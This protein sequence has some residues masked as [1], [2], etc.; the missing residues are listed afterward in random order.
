[1]TRIRIGWAAAPLGLVGAVVAAVV[2]ATAGGAAV[3]PAGVNCSADG[4]ISGRGATFATR[5]WVAFSAGFQDDV[6]GSVPDA[7]GN[8][9]VLYNN[10]TAN[11]GGSGLTGSGKGQEATSCRSDAFGGTDIP[12]DQATLATLNGAPGSIAAGCAA[13]Q[14]YNAFYEPNPSPYPDAADIAAPVMSFPI[15]GSSIVVSVNLTAGDCG[16]SAPGALTFTSEIVSK[17]F[18][19]DITN[20]NDAALRPTVDGIVRNSGLANCNVPVERVVRLDRSGTTQIFKNYLQRADTTRTGATCQP[21]TQWSTFAQDANNTAWP[22]GVGTCSPLTRG[23]VN[24]NTGVLG[25][26]AGTSGQPANPGAVCY[27]DLA[28]QVSGSYPNLI[29]STLRNA[30]DTTFVSAQSGTSRANCNFASISPPGGG[31]AGAVGLNTG[32]NPDNWAIDGPVGNRGDITFRG[33]GYPICGLTF[34][35]VYTGLNN[36]AVANAISRLTANQRRTLYSYMSYILSSGGQARLTIN[37][38]NYQSMPTAL[39]DTLRTGFQNNY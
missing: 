3:P 2:F 28:D 39:R 32:G 37:N 10:P 4:K 17:L 27:A 31:T 5:A 12:Y 9:M 22:D 35:F 30:T 14:T 34:A 24:G 38:V 15:A 19:G 13:F 18:G 23:Y 25:T 6:C 7:Q 21:A 36:G 29:R 11:A 26:C 16:G 33:T 1:M 20:W 8:T